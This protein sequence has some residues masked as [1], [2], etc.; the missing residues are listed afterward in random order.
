MLAGGTAKT[1][2]HKII[3]WWPTE[4]DRRDFALFGR[5]GTWVSQNQRV[6]DKKSSV[7]CV[8]LVLEQFPEL[9]AVE[10]QDFA[11]RLARSIR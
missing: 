10:V 11:G 9:S 3:Y 6:L 8:Q 1:S 7:D 2:N 4:G 5:V